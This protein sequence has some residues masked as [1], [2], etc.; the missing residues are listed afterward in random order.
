[1]VELAVTVWI[2]NDSERETVNNKCRSTVKHRTKNVNAVK[3]GNEIRVVKKKKGI[4][5]HWIDKR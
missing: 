2:A 4:D 3:S 5:G 1:M